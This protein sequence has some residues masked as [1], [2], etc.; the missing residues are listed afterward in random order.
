MP[1]QKPTKPLT[2]DRA[3]ACKRYRDAPGPI[4]AHNPNA[5]AKHRLG[6]FK[7]ETRLKFIPGLERKTPFQQET[8]GAQV[9]AV[10]SK[11]PRP[12]GAKDFGIEREALLLSPLGHQ[13]PLQRLK[14]R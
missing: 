12:E 5:A 9:N 4:D 11:A 10:G 7:L 8:L 14:K 1:I 6:A 13:L 3:E 2:I